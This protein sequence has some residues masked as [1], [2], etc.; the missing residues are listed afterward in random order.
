MSA[1]PGDILYCEGHYVYYQ[2]PKSFSPEI[3]VSMN[4]WQ[5]GNPIRAEWNGNDI[6]IYTEKNWIYKMDNGGGSP[7][8]F[9][10]GS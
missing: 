5:G 8:I 6:Y 2:S 9:K 7:D 10:T 1:K 3:L 4:N